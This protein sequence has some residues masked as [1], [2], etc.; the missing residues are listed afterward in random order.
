[1]RGLTSTAVHFLNILARESQSPYLQHV[2][3][4]IISLLHGLPRSSQCETDEAFFVLRRQWAEELATL[5]IAM[6]ELPHEERNIPFLQE[7]DD[8]AAI[9]SGNRRVLI[10]LCRE[11]G[12]GWKEALC[13]W[14]MWIRIGLRRSGLS[15]VLNPLSL[16]S[17]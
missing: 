16:L 13:V 6:D 11:C 2:I 12:G 15:C 5:R 3:Q 8:L 17:F 4:L 10:K 9:M 1:M 14:G 7:L